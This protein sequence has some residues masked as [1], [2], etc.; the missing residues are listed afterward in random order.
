MTLIPPAGQAK[1]GLSSTQKDV[2][3]VI[4]SL[5]SKWAPKDY[6]F[7]AVTKDFTANTHSLWASWFQQKTWC[8]FQNGKSSAKV[9]SEEIG[10][11]LQSDEWDDLFLDK[12]TRLCNGTNARRLSWCHFEDLLRM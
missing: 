6:T 1:K 5:V 10:L 9:R 8:W 11:G 4:N 7:S 3:A 12:D 2:K